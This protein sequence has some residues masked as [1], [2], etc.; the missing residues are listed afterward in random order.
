SLLIAEGQGILANLPIHPVLLGPHWD[1]VATD[2]VASFRTELEC[3]LGGT[4][5]E[6][7]GSLGDINPT[8]PQ[9]EPGDAYEP[10]A[11][12]EQN[13]DYGK[14]LGQTI[15]ASVGEATA[16]DGALKVIRHET[17]E[18]PVGGT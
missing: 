8:P 14:R 3:E 13:V 2:W 15:L 10:W 7:T 11:T 5:I 6:L 16:L 17:I 1:K 12:L 18:A 4:A 9:G